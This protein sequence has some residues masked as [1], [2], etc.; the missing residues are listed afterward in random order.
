ME[1]RT[2]C[3]P[4]SSYFKNIK[5]HQKTKR[6]NYWKQIEELFQE[7]KDLIDFLCEPCKKSGL[8]SNIII[9]DDDIKSTGKSNDQ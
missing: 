4:C 7:N 9:I 1:K 3:E 2:Y 8:K 5:A 6:H